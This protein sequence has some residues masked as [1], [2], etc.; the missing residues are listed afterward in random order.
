MN[1]INLFFLAGVK[2]VYKKMA[3]KPLK[4]IPILNPGADG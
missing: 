3:F 1:Y 4:S 2:P